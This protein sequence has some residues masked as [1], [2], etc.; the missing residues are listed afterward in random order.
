MVYMAPFKRRRMLRMQDD[1]GFSVGKRYLDIMQYS[2]SPFSPREEFGLAR[3][4]LAASNYQEFEFVMEEAAVKG[5]RSGRLRKKKSSQ[6]VRT[7]SE[8]APPPESPTVIQ[9]AQAVLDKLKPYVKPVLKTAGTAAMT[10]GA[11]RLLDYLSKIIGNEVS[12]EFLN[13]PLLRA[14]NLARFIGD[15]AAE[16]AE[17]PT[18]IAPSLAAEIGVRRARARLS[19]KTR[20]PRSFP[21]HLPES[22]FPKRWP[23]ILNFPGYPQNYGDDV[24]GGGDWH[25]KGN[26]III[27]RCDGAEAP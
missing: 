12:D 24:P 6:A 16:A 8:K 14:R 11:E 7:L 26:Q 21:K 1:D 15:A 25:R 10:W 4:L 19:S 3:K 22:K 9:R 5:A 13:H 27:I 20:R 23:T 18:H 2:F 17:L